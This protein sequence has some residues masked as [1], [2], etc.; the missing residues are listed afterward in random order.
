MRRLLFAQSLHAAYLHR[1]STA[2][3]LLLGLAAHVSSQSEDCPVAWNVLYHHNWV[4]K[5]IH[6]WETH[7]RCAPQQGSRGE[8]ALIVERVL[9]SSTQTTVSK[10]LAL[11]QLLVE[12][13]I[14]AVVSDWTL[15]W[16][17]PHMACLLESVKKFKDG[18]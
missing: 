1:E 17:E 10:E 15:H 16:Q 9:L 2:L 4:F 6:R 18:R 7:D 11:G 14:S 13:L 8:E 3:R 12:A 5:S